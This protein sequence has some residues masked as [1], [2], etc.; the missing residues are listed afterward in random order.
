MRHVTP[1]RS[2]LARLPALTLVLPLLAV[3]TAG[4]G[5]GELPDLSP[6]PGPPVEATPVEAAPPGPVTVHDREF[7][8]LS[9]ARDSTLIVPWFFRAFDGPDRVL[10]R[11]QLW[12][13]RAGSWEALVRE[14]IETAPTRSP[15]QILPVPGIRPGIGDDDRVES[16]RM[17][18]GGREV[19]TRIDAF[20]T[21]W[22]P[23]GGDAVWLSEGRTLFPSGEVEGFVVEVNRRWQSP[24]GGRSDWIFLHSGT[25]LQLFLEGTAPRSASQ[26]S[27]PYRG[28]SRLAFQNATWRI[29]EIEWG[30]LRPFE[31]AR[32]D[33]PSTWLISS[34]GGEIVGEIAA[35]SSHLV[36][37]EG[38]GP[39]LPVSGFFAVEGTV[40]VRGESFE[41][42]GVVRHEQR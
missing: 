27:A 29:L 34:P 20:V 1:T 7:L 41:V 9:M 30:E 12:V 33:I 6:T 31:P 17:S 16:L 32:R 36:V 4:C 5:E 11:V 8:F 18:G 28:W 14:E 2:L 42:V 22:I 13:S 39:I 19:E 26:A 40:G 15:W 10:R 3:I 38:E 35:T 25:Q 24:D 23:P 21:D 37:G